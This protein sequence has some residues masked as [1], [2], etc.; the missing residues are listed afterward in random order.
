[1][2]RQGSLRRAA[3]QRQSDRRSASLV[4]MMQPRGRR[5]PDESATGQI[6]ITQGPRDEIAKR[7]WGS[8]NPAAISSRVAHGR[9]NQTR[10]LDGTDSCAAWKQGEDL[11]A[12]GVADLKLRE[13]MAAELEEALH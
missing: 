4:S 7:K 6:S 11:L 5:A 13:T 1:M 8:P 12:D 10:V 9:C 3:P 2:K